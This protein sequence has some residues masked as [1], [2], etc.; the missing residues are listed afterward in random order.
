MRVN[1]D[2]MDADESDSGSGVEKHPKVYTKRR[3][4]K[5]T[6]VIK[7]TPS[8]PYYLKLGVLSYNLNINL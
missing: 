7:T 2:D 6:K 4:V 3:G 1:D 5:V 8:T